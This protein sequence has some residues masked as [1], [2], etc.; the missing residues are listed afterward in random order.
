MNLPLTKIATDY[1]KVM[2]L[3][4]FGVVTSNLNSISYPNSKIIS[5]QNVK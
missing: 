4:D 3:Y 1:R 2:N 5:Y